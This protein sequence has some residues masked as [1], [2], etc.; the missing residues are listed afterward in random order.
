MSITVGNP[1]VLP[2]DVAVTN[3]AAAISTDSNQ[4]DSVTLL[5]DSNNTDFIKVGNSV[6]QTFP[7]VPGAAVEITKTKLNLIYAVSNSGSQTLHVICGGF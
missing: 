4:R 3:T 7:L 5:A 2:F 6:L 1:T